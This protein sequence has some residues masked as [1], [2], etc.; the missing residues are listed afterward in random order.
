MASQ[1]E[2]QQKINS[3]NLTLQM[4]YYQYNVCAACHPED[5]FFAVVSD[6]ISP[7]K[8][9]YPYEIAVYN[10]F[11]AEDKNRFE[12]KVR[13]RCRYQAVT[14]KSSFVK[15]FLKIKAQTL[16][17]YIFLLFPALTAVK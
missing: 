6:T 10:T 4:E 3:D 12:M 9:E 1:N 7:I 17:F 11:R 14:G 16:L 15:L 13:T 8:Q 5:D 2:K